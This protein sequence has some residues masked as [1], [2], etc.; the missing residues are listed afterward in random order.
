MDFAGTAGFSIASVFRARYRY[1]RHVSPSEKEYTEESK[2]D[3]P[4]YNYSETAA[5][6]NEDWHRFAEL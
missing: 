2:R 1:F 4:G 5:A 3:L 6:A